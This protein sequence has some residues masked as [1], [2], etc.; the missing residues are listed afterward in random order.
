[1]NKSGHRAKTRRGLGSPSFFVAYALGDV[2]IFRQTGTRDEQPR[3][4]ALA[5]ISDLV[6]AFLVI[7]LIGKAII[8]HPVH[9]VAASLISAIVIAAGEWFFHKYLDRNIFPEK[10]GHGRGRSH[11]KPITR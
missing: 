6:V 1:M 5:T 2:G 10:Y 7:W 3:R 11:G 9:L 8:D 4:N